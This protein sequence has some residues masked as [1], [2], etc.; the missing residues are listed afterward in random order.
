MK[1]RKLL[2]ALSAAL[3]VVTLAPSASAISRSEVMARAKAFA[4]HP[5]TCTAPNTSASCN[6]AYVSAYVPGDYVGLPYDWG[7]YMG[8]FEFDQGIAQGKGAGSYPD[9]GIL[10]CTVGLDCSGFVSQAWGTSHYTTSS[11]PQVSSLID[12][13]DLLPGDVFNEAGYHVAMYSHM[14]ANG[15]PALYEALGYNVH[16]NV[17][18]G[19]SHVSGYLPRRFQ[20]I[21]GTTASDPLGTPANPIVI[22]SFPYT[23]SRDTTQS[24]SDV[25][26]GCGAAPNK[27]ETGKEY[28]YKVTLTKPG[29]LTA[30]IMDDATADID[31]HLYTSM[32]TNDC[33]ARNDTTITVDVDCGTYYV[34][35][36][37]FKG[38][39]EY[40]GAYTLNVSFAP[41]AAPCGNG[42]PQYSPSGNLGDA[43]GYP[44][45]PNLP[46]C[47]PNLGS[48]V[49]LYT[50]SSSFC[51]KPCAVNADCAGLQGGCC[52]DI[53]GG[54]TYCFTADLCGTSTPPDPQGQPDAGGDPPLDGGAGTGASGGGGPIGSGGSGQGGS[55]GGAG[56]GDKPPS[57]DVDVKVGCSVSEGGSAPDLAG[58]MGLAI[59]ALAFQNRRSSRSKRS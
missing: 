40:P 58:L 48:D 10:S 25:L 3:A 1:P 31:I 38:A 28:V 20:S 59:A 18:G 30:A 9:D 41:S 7:G 16:V 26:D 23:D 46:F 54:E 6:A 43:C 47:N 22:P 53:G 17:T 42:P 27:A 29:K 50:D 44:G 13:A 57:N 39:T 15:E 5:W 49:C 51:S 55:G 19:W 52:G 36:D 12:V 8:L 33:I 2:Q 11:I 34:V 56:G 35:A 24:P 4:Y 14:L 32:N 21:T 45:D 37:T